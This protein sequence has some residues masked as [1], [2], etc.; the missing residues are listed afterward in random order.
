[1]DIHTKFSPI[2]Y[3]IPT[4]IR[5]DNI[6]KYAK[7]FEMEDTV[8][9]YDQEGN[10]IVYKVSELCPHTFGEEDLKND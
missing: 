4:D 3:E 7:L 2:L 1:M 10:E 9:T 5:E 8:T 6:K